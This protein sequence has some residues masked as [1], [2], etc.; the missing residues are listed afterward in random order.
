MLV[1][2]DNVFALKNYAL[3]LKKPMIHGGTSD[4]ERLDFLS[5]F[6]HDSNMNCLFISKVGDNSIDLPDGNASHNVPSTA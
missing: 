2:S 1:F 6:Q 4:N 5:H 3:T